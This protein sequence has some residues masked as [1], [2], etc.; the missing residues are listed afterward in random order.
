MITRRGLLAGVLATGCAGGERTPPVVGEIVGRSDAERGHASGS[1]AV[2]G[3]ERVDVAILG[4]GIGGLSAAWRLRRAG[5]DGTVAHV[6]L[7]DRIGGTAQGDGGFPWGAHYVTLPNP[8]AA[9]YRAILA[10]LGVITGFD[11]DGRPRFDDRALCYAPQE[12]LW[13]GQRWTEGLL[14]ETLAPQDAAQVA[15]FEALCRA[16]RDRRGADGLRAFDIPVAHSSA[17]PAFRELARISFADWLA[18]Q[19]LDGWAVRWLARYAVRDDFGSEPEAVSAW[20]GLHYHCARAPDPAMRDLGTQVLTWPQGNGWL[21]AALAA[22]SPWPVATG[23]VVRQLEAED[24]Q[25]RVVVVQGERTREIVART[26]IAALPSRVVARWLPVATVPDLAPWRIAALHVDRLPSGPGLAFAWD[27]VLLGA[28]GLGYVSNAH[29]TGAF[30]GPAVLTYYDPL[31]GGLP[32]DGRRALL[33]AAWA[34][35]ADLVL[36]D[37]APAHPD[38]RAVVRRVDVR[39]WGHGT[40]IPAVGLHADPGWHHVQP[41]PRVWL[42]HT[43]R[44]GMSLFEEASWHGVRAAEGALAQ[45]GRPPAERL[46]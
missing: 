18:A 26:V 32:A 44:S 33:G 14:P 12:R 7:G 22:R 38:L 35:E 9:H 5:F 10:D 45:L 17:D 8:G 16:W 23:A 3:S 27:S 6:E 29:Q 40:T 28:R 4:A 43:D 30:R 24:E 20:A 11:P 31:S 46:C 25:V 36:A 19:G 39:H 34:D 13:D 2:A 1:G 15:A 41:H 21:V 42:A 37:L